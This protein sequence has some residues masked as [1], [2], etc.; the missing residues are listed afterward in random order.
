MSLNSELYLEQ[1]VGTLRLQFHQ[2]I[3]KAGVSATH[4]R[5][6][7]GPG[8][9]DG[10]EKELSFILVILKEDQSLIQ[11]YK[12]TLTSHSLSYS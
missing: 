2:E 9:Q 12:L 6:V 1:V 8:S 10:N 3:K 4:S 11:A 7:L 5:E